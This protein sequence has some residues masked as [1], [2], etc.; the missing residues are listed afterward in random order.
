MTEFFECGMSMIKVIID[1]HDPA[2]IEAQH[3]LQVGANA[4]KV[5]TVSVSATIQVS[6]VGEGND[7]LAF[8]PI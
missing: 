1:A 5:E 4:F 8:A 6:I 7:P 3:Q 2:R